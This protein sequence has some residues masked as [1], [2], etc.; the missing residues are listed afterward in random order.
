ML[1]GSV[2]SKQVRFAL[3][4]IERQ[5]VVCSASSFFV[6]LYIYYE[7]S[8]LESDSL[9]YVHV[10]VNAAFLH[11]HAAFLHVRATCPCC[12]SVLH[13]HVAYPCCMP[14]LHEHA[15]YHSTNKVGP[16]M[17]VESRGVTL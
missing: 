17:L 13:V 16:V 12:M 10:K 7:L 5:S 8:C 9:V 11:A 4:I 14:L 15:V 3:R 6:L 1:K 2:P